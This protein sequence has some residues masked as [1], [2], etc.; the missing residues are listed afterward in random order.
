MPTLTYPRRPQQ[1]PPES[2]ALGELDTAAA[3]ALL[4]P[5]PAGAP[6][7]AR[8]RGRSTREPG[9]S[10]ADPT[11]DPDLDWRCYNPDWQAT[12]PRGPAALGFGDALEGGGSGRGALSVGV[13]GVHDDLDGGCYSARYTQHP[14]RACHGHVADVIAS[15]PTT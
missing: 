6:D 12:R 9:R 5:T 2:A 1:K 13:A 3:D 7:M 8:Q 14:P 11:N 4:Y 15:I 10:T